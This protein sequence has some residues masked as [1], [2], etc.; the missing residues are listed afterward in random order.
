MGKLFGT[1]PVRIFVPLRLCSTK[2]SE[3]SGTYLIAVIQPLFTVSPVLRAPSMLSIGQ[4]HFPSQLIH[5]H[6]VCLLRS[7]AAIVYTSTGYNSI[8]GYWVCK[9]YSISDAAK[10]ESIC[11]IRVLALP[12]HT[13]QS[14]CW[15]LFFLKS[16]LSY[17]SVF[18]AP[19]L[20]YM[21]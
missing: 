16:N 3:E 17:L 15:W 7:W 11:W 6:Q 13:I 4:L 18:L 8:A 10:A 14:L 2:F 20:V 1:W 19:T 5:P 9:T 21:L 12:Q